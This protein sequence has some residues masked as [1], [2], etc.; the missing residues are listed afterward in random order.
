MTTLQPQNYSI[1]VVASTQD[2][3]LLTDIL[4]EARY[5]VQSVLDGKQALAAAARQAPDLILL[6]IDIADLDGFETC[7]QLKAT[8]ATQDIPVIFISALNELKYEMKAFAAG[9]VDYITKPFQA[10][11]LLVR[12]KTHLSLGLKQQDLA[13]KSRKLQAE[14][15][16]LQSVTEALRQSETRYRNLFN[17]NHSVML[18]IDPDDGRIVD[19]NPAASRFYGY[20]REVLLKMRISDINTKSVTAVEADMEVA[21]QVVRQNFNSHHRLADGNIREVDVFSGPLVL[22]DRQLLY[23][24]IY[25]VTERRQTER[26]LARLAEVVEQVAETVIITDTD[27]TIVYANPY[28]EKVTGY[29]PAELLGQNP[30]VF[31]SGK[32][33]RDFYQN[34]WETLLRGEIW[35]GQFINRRQDGT[36]FH[37]EAVLFPIKD[38]DGSVLNYA[39]VKRDVT[40]QVQ[41][42]AELEQVLATVPEAIMVVDENGR[43]QQANPTAQAYLSTLPGAAEETIWQRLGNEELP[44]LLAD[45]QLQVPRDI[46]VGDQIFQIMGRQIKGEGQETTAVVALLNVT[47]E[48][49]QQARI[50]ENNRLAAVGQ[51]AAGIAHDFNN[52]MAVIPLYAQLALRGKA[53]PAVSKDRLHTIVEQADRAADL[54]QQILDFSRSNTMQRT[55]LNL[56]PFLKEQV[57]ILRR[58]LPENVTITFENQIQDAFVEADPT[59]IQQVIVNLSLNARDAI[60]D[61]GELRLDLAQ[62]VYDTA[63]VTPLPDMDPGT[64]QIIT[65]TDTGHGIAPEHLGH[66]FEPFFTTKTPQKGTGLGLSQVYGIILQHGGHIDVH[67][68]LE[69]GTTF[70]IYLPA[71]TI[72]SSD[73]TSVDQSTLPVG[74]GQ[75]VLLVEDEPTIQ[76]VVVETL[77][78]LNYRVITAM[79][80]DMALTMLREQKDEIDLVLS[81]VVMPRMGGVEMLAAARDMGLETPVLLMS[82]YVMEENLPVLQKYGAPPVIPKPLQINALADMLYEQLHSENVKE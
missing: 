71:I 6:G 61:Y 2:L 65:I 68:Q 27:G 39:A 33:D 22:N 70:T 16:T 7:Q 63:V 82:G 73:H 8:P 18:I 55:P 81:D 19:A 52:I 25:D 67:S 48:R 54:I 49:E 58:T 46:K 17:N 3:Q 75:L 1:L 10:E 60:G 29:K 5:R 59:R 32:Q 4:T 74:A 66:I 35:Q 9:G 56:V 26:Q 21:A 20:P 31:N 30:R 37:E 79:D 43:V 53:L 42:L 77:E 38:E 24:I 72:S 80:G 15:E 76:T 57:K 12:V 23:S 14:S 51:L 28:V 36:L 69:E 11:A 47:E 78:M 41:L 62:A 45:N 44:H 40:K 13:A 64:W 34:M 50:Q